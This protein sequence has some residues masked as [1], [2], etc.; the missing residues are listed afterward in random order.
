[1]TDWLKK[2][3]RHNTGTALIFARTETE[4]Y[5]EFVWPHASGIP[6]YAEGCISTIQMG[7]EPKPTPELPAFWS[8][9]AWKMWN[10]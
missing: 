10:G 5:H 4:A 1:M 9:M 8:P 7:A 6:S 2:M 3:S